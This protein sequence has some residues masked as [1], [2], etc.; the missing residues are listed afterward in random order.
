MA[1]E[2]LKNTKVVTFKEDYNAGGMLI[3]KKG[4]THPIHKKTVEVLKEKGV[5]MDVK[6]YDVDAEIDK[7]KAKFDKAKDKEG[8]EK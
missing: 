1:H 8:S 4:S 6:D 2:R 3:Y 7:A 5:K